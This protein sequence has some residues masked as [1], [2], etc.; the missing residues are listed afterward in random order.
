MTRLITLI[1]S[2]SLCICACKTNQKQQSPTISKSPYTFDFVN[3]SSIAELTDRAKK[4][5]KLIFL[6]VYTDW[7]MPCKTMDKEVFSDKKLGKF[8]NEHFISYKANAEKGIGADAA[9]MYDVLGFPTLLFLNQKGTL[10][11]KKTGIA[12]NREMYELADEALYL[13]RNESGE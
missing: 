2:L 11:I 8:F 12:Y 5:N 13:S 6:D 7:C 1:L 10:L 3:T 9:S 4:E